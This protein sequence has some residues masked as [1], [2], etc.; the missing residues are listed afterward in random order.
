VYFALNTIEI[1][2]LSILQLF[3][4]LQFCSTKLTIYKIKHDTKINVKLILQQSNVLSGI[5]IGLSHIGHGDEY[6]INN[7]KHSLH[8]LCLQEKMTN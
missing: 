2:L 3:C 8:V 5:S 1:V 7:G 4:I 6:M